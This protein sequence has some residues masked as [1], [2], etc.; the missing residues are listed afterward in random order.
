MSQTNFNI[1]DYIKAGYPCVFM[2][3]G[4]GAKAERMV[5]EALVDLGYGSMQFGSWKI[6]SG[7]AVDTADGS[8]AADKKGQQ[9]PEALRYMQDQKRDNPIVAVFHNL[10]QLIGNFANIQELIDT[11]EV[12]SYEGSN[13]ILVGPYLEL[14]IELTNYVSVLD[15]PLPG[16]DEL[17][18]QF[19]DLV[20]AY[21]K[22]VKMPK[23]KQ[24]RKDL[25]ETAAQ[26]AL[27]LDETGAMNALS[28]SI[29]TTGR[30]DIAT[31]QA[32]KAHEVR[33]SDTLEF[34]EHDESI[35]NVGGFDLFKQD[36]ARRQRVFTPEA[37][38]FGLPYPKG[39]LIVGPGGTGKSLTAKAYASYLNLPL[40]RMDMGR[41]FRSL[42]GESEAAIRQALDVAEAVSPVVL[43]LDE[44]DK[45]MAGMAGS[46]NLD[47]G[48][49]A[50]VMQ[51][52][53][54]WRQETDKPV[55]MFATANDV[56]SLPA[57]VYRKGR[58]DEVWATDLPHQSEREEI[59]AI[60][61]RKVGRTTDDHN[62]ELLAQRAE[63]FV[64]S[65][66]E[67]VV[68][69]AL[70]IA[71]SRDEE[72]SDEAI[73]QAIGETTPSSVR[74]AEEI[75]AIRNWVST[76]ARRVSSEPEVEVG[77]N[78]GK[79]IRHIKSTKAKK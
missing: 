21:E 45:G 22:N 46:G 42:V 71:F 34:V 10:R 11:I 64:G 49:T 13:L 74:D 44:I 75:T 37:R 53:L 54:T 3:C 66:I 50:R 24:D 57:P 25:L 41:I 23:K 18:S 17:I 78:G 29:V 30:V 68:A 63:G 2:R 72:L 15:V 47:S 38:E 14:P 6:T 9:L 40:L 62:L 52:L 12:I 8:T 55:V 36:L 28:L 43:W 60:H 73:L 58:F 56:A 4:D 31:I 70:F 59:F 5:R 76:R 69:D 26:S 32:Q 79:K 35:Q 1:S 51:T 39:A 67:S 33:K 65:E 19:D 77:D 27:G 61:I 7:F 20:K 48:V 16:R